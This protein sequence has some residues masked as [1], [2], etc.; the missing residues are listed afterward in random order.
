MLDFL[1]IGTN[2]S[3]PIDPLL[4]ERKTYLVQFHGVKDNGSSEKKTRC[5]WVA[6]ECC[7]IFRQMETSWWLEIRILDVKI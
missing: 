6:L 5:V 1:R 2:F 4:Y 3:C 7:E